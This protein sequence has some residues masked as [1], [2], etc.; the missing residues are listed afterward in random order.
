MLPRLTVFG[1]TLLGSGLSSLYAA[2]A[3][4]VEFAPLFWYILLAITSGVAALFI[5]ASQP[6]SQHIVRATDFLFPTNQSQI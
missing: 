1:V 6:H 5:K 4:H 2:Y 3:L